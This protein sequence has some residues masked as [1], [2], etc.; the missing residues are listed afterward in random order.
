MQ[1]SY[2]LKNRKSN[3]EHLERGWIGD[4]KKFNKDLYVILNSFTLW[5]VRDNQLFELWTIQIKYQI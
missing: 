1:M 4:F 5:D 3:K 2:L